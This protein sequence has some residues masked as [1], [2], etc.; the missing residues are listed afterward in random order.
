VL[1]R[2]EGEGKVSDEPVSSRLQ[3]DGCEAA[4]Q[5]WFPDCDGGVP[6]GNGIGVQPGQGQL[7]GGGKQND[8]VGCA[9]PVVDQAGI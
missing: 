2:A 6:G 4:G 9:A 5:V 8:R 7:V 1:A 3:S